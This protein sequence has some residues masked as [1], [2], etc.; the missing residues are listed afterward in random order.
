[1]TV[2]PILPWDILPGCSYDEILFAERFVNRA[3]VLRKGGSFGG[4]PVFDG[5]GMVLNSSTPD[6]VKYPLNEQFDYGLDPLGV[7]AICIPPFAWDEGGI[8]RNFFD[9][10]PTLELRMTKG[11]ADN[12]LFNV[13]GT[14][15][16]N[17][18]SATI[19]PIWIQNGFNV[20]T[21]SASDGDTNA[22]INKTQ[23]VTSS[24]TAYGTIPALTELGIGIRGTTL[25]PF[26]GRLL[27]IAFFKRLLTAEDHEALCDA[28]PMLVIP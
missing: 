10:T 22:W 23:I 7:H 18:A 6:Y 12:F 4:N 1:M 15:I 24:V 17:V 16:C 9:C 11:S 26:N 21:V 27:L 25:G 28:R 3:S 2:G 14:N 19:D 5:N 8:E 13:G 20:I